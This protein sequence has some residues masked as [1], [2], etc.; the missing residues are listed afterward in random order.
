MTRLS[1][2]ALAGTAAFCAPAAADAVVDIDGRTAT[3]FTPAGYN[4]GIPAPVVMLLHGFGSSGQGQENYMQFSELADEFGFLYVYPDGTENSLPARFW[5]A[6]DACC[7]VFGSGVDDS[8]YLR[9][10]CGA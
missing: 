10:R 1:L 8:A 6:T 2:L 7:D 3:V 5:N 4:P 9:A